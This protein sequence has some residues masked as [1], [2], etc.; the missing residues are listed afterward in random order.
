MVSFSIFVIIHFITPPLPLL[1]QMDVNRKAEAE[2]QRLM[3]AIAATRVTREEVQ[4]KL[5]QSKE[6][7]FTGDN[8]D[9][10]FVRELVIGRGGYYKV[11]V[12]HH[13]A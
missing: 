6:W 2:R 1:P 5:G 9:G 8:V 3:G 12:H 4:L 13:R 11:L 7:R 10:R